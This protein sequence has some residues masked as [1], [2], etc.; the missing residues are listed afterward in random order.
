M[1]S[2]GPAFARFPPIQG[3]GS[4]AGSGGASTSSTGATA[5]MAS[6]LAPRP[7]VEP[8]EPRWS[9]AGSR[10]RFSSSHFPQEVEEAG[11]GVG[12]GEE[13]EEEEEEE[14][15]FA[16]LAGGG[17][18]G[19]GGGDVEDETAGSGSGGE[20]EEEEEEEECCEGDE[21]EADDCG[22]EGEGDEESE[23]DGG[24]GGGTN[25]LCAG[26]PWEQR[27]RSSTGAADDPPRGAS[28]SSSEEGEGDAE[29]GA[30]TTSPTV[31]GR[32]NGPRRGGHGQRHYFTS[33]GLAGVQVQVEVANME[34]DEVRPQIL[35]RSQQ[36][37]SVN[38]H[39]VL[40][41]ARSITNVCPTARL[42]LWDLLL[43]CACLSAS[44]STASMRRGQRRGG[45]GGGECGAPVAGSVAQASRDER[46][47]P[48]DVFNHPRAPAAPALQRR[49][50]RRDRR[51][52][53]RARGTRQGLTVVP[54]PAQLEHLCP[55]HNPK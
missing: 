29:W 48:R 5:A 32:R 6:P 35:A 37:K 40:G 7:P 27:P 11:A 26:S 34:V 33:E 8:R 9:G 28:G 39:P 50:P 42:P 21:G 25:A 13:Q 16:E 22:D 18:G 38:R 12:A 2:S 45:G 23:E 1:P 55:P 46:R 51:W 52:G 3:V 53:D 43:T 19:S 4:R 41:S 17:G 20:E 49:R 15:E 47:A 10:I 54:I 30:H 36:R 31:A 14:G 44:F 24:D